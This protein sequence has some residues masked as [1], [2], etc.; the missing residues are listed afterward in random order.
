MFAAKFAEISEM[1][2]SR[3]NSLINGE[4]NNLMERKP[5]YLEGRFHGIS[6]QIMSCP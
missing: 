5:A 4:V 3:E 6:R 2:E 1:G